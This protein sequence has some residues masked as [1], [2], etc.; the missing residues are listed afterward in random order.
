MDKYSYILIIVAMWFLIKPDFILSNYD[1]QYVNYIRE[2]SSVIGV[3][4]LIVF[5]I[6]YYKDTNTKTEFTELPSYAEATSE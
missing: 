4:C 2:K 3:G 5:G 1:N 6:M